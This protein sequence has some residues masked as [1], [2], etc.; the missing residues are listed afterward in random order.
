MKAIIG[1]KT[2]KPKHTGVSSVVLAQNSADMRKVRGSKT[3]TKL[4][5]HEVSVECWE[6]WGGLEYNNS[7]GTVPSHVFMHPGVL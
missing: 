6:Q 1:A 7:A 3:A 5:E 4:W 2:I